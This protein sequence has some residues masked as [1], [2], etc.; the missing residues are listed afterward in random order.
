M[1]LGGLDAPPVAF[2][3]DDILRLRIDDDIEFVDEDGIGPW[4]TNECVGCGTARE[5]VVSSIA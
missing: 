3:Y 5:G 4:A 1:G 2:R